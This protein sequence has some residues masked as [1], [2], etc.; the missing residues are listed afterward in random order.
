MPPTVPQPAAQVSNTSTV[1]GEALSRIGPQVSYRDQQKSGLAG[2][3]R[4]GDDPR[5]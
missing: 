4:G 3:R 5:R 1:V 2:A